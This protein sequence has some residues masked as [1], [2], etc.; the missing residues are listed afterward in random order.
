MKTISRRLVALATPAAAAL[1]AATLTLPSSAAAQQ[2]RDPE[3]IL[4]D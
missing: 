3:A 1:V 2:P 4:A